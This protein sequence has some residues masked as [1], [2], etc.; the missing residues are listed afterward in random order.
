M[1]ADHKET[2]LMRAKSG[3]EPYGTSGFIVASERV[4]RHQMNERRWRVGELADVTG[5]TVRTLHHY[6]QTGLLAAAGRTSGDHR[7]YDEAGVERLYRIRALRGL[8]L[9]LEETKK[10]LA[11]G[12]ALAEVLRAH[13]AHIESEVECMTHLRD[14]LRSILSS[15]AHISTDDLLVT[16]DAMSSV[17]RH[18]HARQ[19]KRAAQHGNAEAQWRA[20]GDKL[21]ACMDAGKNPSSKRVREIASQ[22]RLRIEAFAGGDS[23]ILQALA[24]IR[25][26]DPPRDLAGWTPELMRYFDCALASLDETQSKHIDRK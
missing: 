16:L 22:V 25:A 2:L 7:L 20:L 21:R 26:V 8:G 23:T 12:S 24:R 11:D 14:R 5:M 13:L 9:S 18:V 6:E 3:L 4:K 15:E 10:V 1:K 19:S 17:E